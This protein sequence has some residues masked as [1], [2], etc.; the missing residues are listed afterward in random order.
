MNLLKKI[1]LISSLFF[2]TEAVG[3]SAPADN[4]KEYTLE[5]G[6]QV[7]LLEDKSDALVHMTFTCHAGFSSQT[8]NTCGFF[9]LFARLIEH[10]ASS[11][12]FADVSCNSDSTQYTLNVTP[13]QLDTTLDSLSQN[14]FSPIFTDEQITSELNILKNEISDNAETLSTYINAAIDSRVFSDA[15]WKNDS[16]IYPPLFKKTTSKTARNILQDISLRWYIP[17][18]SAIFIYGNIN[19]ERLLLSLKQTFGRFYSN[20]NTPVEKPCTPVNNQRKYVFH[21][22]EISKELTQIVVQYT[23][24]SLEECNLLSAIL[25]NDASIFKQ[26]I[27]NIQELNIPGAEYI[28]ISPA[29]KRDSSRLIIQTL[30]QPPENKS[31]SVTSEEQVQDFISQVNNI[32]SSID[33]IEIMFAKKQLEAS[34]NSISSTPATLMQNLC[35][36]WA[37]EPFIQ[38]SESDREMYEDSVLTSMML[39]QSKNINNINIEEIFPKLQSENPFIFVMINSNDY[40]K[41]KKAYD[42]AGFEEINENNS[43]WYVQTMFKEIRDQM[44]PEKTNSYY[45]RNTKNDNAY[46]ER[47]LSEIHTRQLENGIKIVS[48]HNPNSTGISMLLSVKGGKLN[49]ADNNGFEEVMINL[50][51]G[52]IEKDIARKQYEGLITGYPLVSTQTDISTSS[53]IIEFDKEDELAICESVSNSIVFGEIAPAAADKAVSSRQYRKRLENGSAVNQMYSAAVKYIYGKTDL[54]KIFDSEKDVL[55]STDYS[56]ILAAYPSLLDAKRYS[57]II[58]GDFDDDIFPII[59]KCFSTLSSSNFNEPAPQNIPELVKNKTINVKIRHTFL[60]DIPAEKA[61]PQPAVLIP[62]TEF[63]DPV[64]YIFK[65]PEAGTKDAAVYNAMLNYISSELQGAINRNKKFK[66]SSTSI[67]LPSS[68]METGTIIIQNVAHTKEADSTYKNTVSSILASLKDAT[69]NSKIVQNIQNQWMLSYMAE[70]STNSGT[71]KL[72]NRGLEIKSDDFVPEYFLNEYNYVMSANVQDF[73]NILDYF[74]QKP[75]LRVYSA[76]GKE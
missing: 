38:T 16:G 7:F 61:G 19:S 62:T 3:F 71:A 18:N 63:L 47:N 6:M 56:S 33:A 26:Q 48:K 36:Y 28:N 51:A 23:M 53:I 37:Y 44:K 70:T 64:I 32:S 66:G 45:S 10:T 50:M 22:P 30:M 68:K 13:Q 52:I 75:N 69:I 20:Y 21:H 12:S 65:S 4:V 72:I 55:T 14:M 57:I 40:K 17:R 15:P 11:I 5:N 49:S 29:H 2:L 34:L 25:N 43:S 8:Q 60:T 27:L 39:Q 74:P 73:I 35:D 9:K 1:V 59:E 31:L 24:L 54:P 67:Q 76:E 46:Y 58:T 41:N 42:N